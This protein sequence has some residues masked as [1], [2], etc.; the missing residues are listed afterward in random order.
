MNKLKKILYRSFEE[1]LSDRDRQALQAGLR[2]SEELQ[3]EKQEILTLRESLSAT[4]T[5]FSTGF[6]QKVMNRIRQEEQP[7]RT[8]ELYPVFRTVAFSGLAA[9]LIVLVGIYFTDGSLNLD[10]IMGIS[11]YAPDLGLLAFL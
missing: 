7:A 10:A 2:A 9:I 6:D 1:P 11:K 4:R 3:N 8:F 5:D